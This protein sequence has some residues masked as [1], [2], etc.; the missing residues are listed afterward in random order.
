MTDIDYNG[1]S[2][3]AIV[4]A[5]RNGWSYAIDRETGKLIYATPFATATSVNGVSNGQMTTD[6]ALRPT[7]DK[8]VFTCPSFLGGKNWW[9]I[10]VD[11]QT[12]Y[13]YVPTMHTCM[14]S[15]G[16]AVSYKAGLPFLGETFNVMRDPKFPN[17]WGEVQAIDVN[18][19][20]RAWTYPS[21]LPWNDGMLSTAG[22]LVFSGGTDGHLYAFDAKTGKVLW[23]SPEMTSGVIGVPATWRSNGKQYIGVYAGWGGATPLWG[24]DMAKDTAVL[25][26]PTGGHLYVFSL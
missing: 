21:A 6:P 23:K 25:S 15:K 1:T 13:A 10:S 9:P 12:H 26:I 17:T 20:K 7:V 11:P 24:G 19:G 4:T 8:Q 2:H 16:A 18:T 14:T 5:S 3:K 22:G